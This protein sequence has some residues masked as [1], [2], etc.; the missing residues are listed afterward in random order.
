MQLGLHIVQRRA[1]RKV[2]ERAGLSLEQGL[3][4]IELL[5]QLEV[6]HDKPEDGA[7]LRVDGLDALL[8][9][10]GSDAEAMLKLIRGRVAEARR[11]LD[12]HRIPLVFVVEGALTVSASGPMLELDGSEYSLSALGGSNLGRVGDSDAWWWTAQVG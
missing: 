1:L 8:R 9:A 4:V 6:L 11:Y 12:P 3:G 5:R 10:A 7:P 2:A